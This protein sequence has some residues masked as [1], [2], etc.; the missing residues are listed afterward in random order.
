MRIPRS[1]SQKPK[2]TKT[3]ERSDH[4]M[5]RP[6]LEEVCTKFPPLEKKMT[7]PYRFDSTELKIQQQ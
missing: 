5:E 3:V 2:H 7:S 4:K 1:L 6:D